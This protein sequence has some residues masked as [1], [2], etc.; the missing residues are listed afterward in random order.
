MRYLGP[1]PFPVTTL[2]DLWDVEAAG[3]QA[4]ARFEQAMA[5]FSQVECDRTD[6]WEELDHANDQLHWATETI[7]GLIALADSARGERRVTV[8]RSEL[9]HLVEGNRFEV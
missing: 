7:E 5:E 2:G 1:V 3:A 4:A 9:A 6:A 8:L